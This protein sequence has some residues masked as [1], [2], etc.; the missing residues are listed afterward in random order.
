MKLLIRVQ[1]CP[2]CNMVKQWICENKIEGIDYINADENLDLCRKLKIS[3]VPAL[4]LDDENIILG[5]DNIMTELRRKKDAE[6]GK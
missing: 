1:G 3:S 4:I 6:N 5:N 2:N